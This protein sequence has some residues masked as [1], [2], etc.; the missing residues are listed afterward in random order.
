[1]L[2]LRASCDRLVWTLLLQGYDHGVICGQRLIAF[3]VVEYIPKYDGGCHY[4]P[5]LSFASRA[6]L[7]PRFWYHNSSNALLIAAY[8]QERSQLFHFADMKAFASSSPTSL[9]LTS[10][11]WIGPSRAVL[12]CHH[13]S[14]RSPPRS[15]LSMSC[16]NFFK[17]S[18]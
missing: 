8:K 1:M 16:F 9:A 11:C 15:P 12:I 18:L 2:N 7:H 17:K 14:L 10:F 13:I 6:N 4:Y 5:F 3:Y